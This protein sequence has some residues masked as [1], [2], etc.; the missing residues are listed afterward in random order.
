MDSAQIYVYKIMLH[1]K[2]SSVSCFTLR[3]SYIGQ[4]Q[5]N[6]CQNSSDKEKLDS[7]IMNHKIIQDRHAYIC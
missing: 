1:D 6:V 4:Q 7:D 3:H 5:K 2:R